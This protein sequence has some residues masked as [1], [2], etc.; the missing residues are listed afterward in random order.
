[1]IVT[2]RGVRTAWNL[3][4]PFYE[5]EGFGADLLLLA[6][7]DYRLWLWPFRSADWPL[8]GA[9]SRPF[10]ACG[11]SPTPSRASHTRG[12]TNFA[13][14]GRSQRTR[15][16]DEACSAAAAGRSGRMELLLTSLWRGYVLNVNERV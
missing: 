2:Y 14:L 6:A 15:L 1:M 4:R 9:N 11:R 3:Q 5:I 13:N 16:W 7:G 12:T 10:E 8:P